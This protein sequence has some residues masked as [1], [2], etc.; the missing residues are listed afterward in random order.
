MVLPGG[1]M[2][3]C[4]LIERD[5]YYYLIQYIWLAARLSRSVILSC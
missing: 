5:A 3:V 1:K 2:H 4:A